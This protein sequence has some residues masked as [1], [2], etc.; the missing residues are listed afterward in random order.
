[1]C[2]Y[3]L[4]GYGLKTCS[5][6]I[7]GFTSLQGCLQC[8]H[9]EHWT[10]LY[11][12]SSPKVSKYDKHWKGWQ[13]KKLSS[14]IERKNHL[15]PRLWSQQLDISGILNS[16]CLSSDVAFRW[17]SRAQDAPRSHNGRR[18]EEIQHVTKHHI[19]DFGHLKNEPRRFPSTISKPVWG[20]SPL[21][22]TTSPQ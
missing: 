4:F 17:P 1:M 21:R 12:A 13:P 6:A 7:L 20:N 10:M 11:H 18:S 22:P 5:T 2:N 9:A 8:I 15:C 19:L 16:N 3:P 14:K